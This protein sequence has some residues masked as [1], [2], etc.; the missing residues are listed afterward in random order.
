MAICKGVR[1][2]LNS[3]ARSAPA[4]AESASRA[5]RLAKRIIMLPHWREETHTASAQTRRPKLRRTTTAG[6]AE[7]WLTHDVG[8]V[9]GGHCGPARVSWLRKRQ[10]S[11][12]SRALQIQ[13]GPKV[14]I[15]SKSGPSGTCTTWGL[16]ARPI[17]PAGDGGS[18]TQSERFAG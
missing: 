12:S 6:S 7:R 5:A 1:A 16:A 11:T 14:E 9:V 4:G 10:N 17:G 2:E 13:N 8:L 18:R 3:R 15:R